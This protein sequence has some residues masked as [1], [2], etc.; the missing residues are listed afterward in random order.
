MYQTA[1]HMRMICQWCLPPAENSQV[2]GNFT[3][4]HM[5]TQGCDRLSGYRLSFAMTDCHPKSS[6]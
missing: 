3:G 1:S 6:H 5:H 4:R 2:L